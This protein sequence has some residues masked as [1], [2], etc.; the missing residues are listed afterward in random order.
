MSDELMLSGSL[1]QSLKT[2]S[3]W[4][5]K[6]IDKKIQE[7]VEQRSS[8]IA[9]NICRELKAVGQVAGLGL[10][11][12]L[13][14]IK[15]NWGNYDDVG[16]NFEDT[17]SDYA[18]INI[19]TID[20]YLKVWTMKENG[21][22]PTELEKDIFDRNIKEIIP[23]ANTIDQGYEI[24]KDEWGELAI[25]PDLNTVSSICRDIKGQPPRKSA[26]QIVMDRDGTLNAIQAGQVEHVGFL[27]VQEYEN[28][29]AQKAIARLVSSGGIIKR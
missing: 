20:R 3:D 5:F 28:A 21:I 19:T 27:N 15:Q 24:D 26:L 17:I 6:Q 2:D 12:T 18:G 10:A 13:Y 8:I 22:V 14:Q 11:K 23:I 25:A 9:L 4:I 7:S 16:D 1:D 29:I